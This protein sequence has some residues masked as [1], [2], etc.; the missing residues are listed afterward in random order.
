MP[1]YLGRS[2][3][4]AGGQVGCVGPGRQT[5]ESRLNTLLNGKNIADVRMQPA[6]SHVP[7]TRRVLPLRN[8]FVVHRMSRYIE[9]RTG[10]VFPAMSVGARALLSD[11][12]QEDNKA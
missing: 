4:P 7:E 12:I 3:R 2:R 5:D 8:R 6:T 1:I 10:R 11:E 9:C